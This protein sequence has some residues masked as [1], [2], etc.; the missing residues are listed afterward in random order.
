MDVCDT[1]Y[2]IVPFPNPSRA[3][4]NRKFP[5]ETIVDLD[6]VYEGKN[7]RKIRW[8]FLQSGRLMMTPV[9]AEPY[10]IWYAYT[11]LFFEDDMDLW[12]AIG[13]DDKANTWVNDLPVWVSGDQ[14]KGW[15]AE[16]GFRKVAF[17]AGRNR[18]LYRV[19]NGWSSTHFS[20]AVHV[21]D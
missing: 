19:E 21:V 3:N 14:L 6:A 10:G 16:E 2:T 15:R 4:M 13:S 11:E 20:L 8:E 9:H 7:G 12:I 18:V 17:T 5:P 1:W